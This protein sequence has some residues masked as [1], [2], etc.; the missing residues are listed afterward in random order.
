MSSRQ[1]HPNNNGKTANLSSAATSSIPDLLRKALVTND[2]Q[3]GDV[4]LFWRI[5]PASPVTDGIVTVLDTC[6]DLTRADVT[7][8]EVDGTRHIKHVSSEAVTKEARQE[9]DV[10]VFSDL[11][12]LG[13][14][15]SLAQQERGVMF[16]FLVHP[17]ERA[18][19][20]FEHLKA[21]T[22]DVAYDPALAAMSLLDYAR[23]RVARSGGTLRESDFVVRSLAQIPTAVPLHGGHVAHAEQV[24]RDYCL[25]GLTDDEATTRES[26]ER[27]KK[28]FGWR[29][30]AGTHEDCFEEFLPH[31][32][33]RKVQEGSEEYGLLA[34]L[35]KYDMMFY[36]NVRT[37]FDEQGKHPVFRKT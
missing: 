29:R 14:M 10:M 12:R 5:P 20:T 18:A 36:E 2:D 13:S 27:M 30:V 17:V 9:P 22:N 26:V 31:V 23:D 25:V 28:L 21:A 33:E 11:F 7:E 37:I 1:H 32:H 34:E 16:T 35:N 24:L 4:P 19:R 6:Y 15:L 8:A 3:D